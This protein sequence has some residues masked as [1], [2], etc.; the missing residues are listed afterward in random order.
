MRAVLLLVSLILLNGCNQETEVTGSTTN[1]CATDLFPSS[2]PKNLDQCVAACLKCDRGV[3]T[4][5]STS[6]RLKGAE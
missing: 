5:C 6:C 1:S 4:T 2:N 3:M